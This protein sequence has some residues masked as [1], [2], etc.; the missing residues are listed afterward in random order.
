MRIAVIFTAHTLWRATLFPQRILLKIRADKQKKKKKKNKKSLLFP[1]FSFFSFSFSL[2][3]FC[4]SLVR[5]TAPVAPPPLGTPL[6]PCQFS[7]LLCWRFFSIFFFFL[8]MVIY[9]FFLSMVIFFFFFLSM[10]IFF[11]W[12]FFF[13]FFFIHGFFFFFLLVTRQGGGGQPA[14]LAPLVGTPLV[15][16][17]GSFKLINSC[18]RFYFVRDVIP[19]F[20]S[21]WL[22]I[23]CTIKLCIYPRGKQLSKDLDWDLRFL[24]GRYWTS[25]SCR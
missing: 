5:E 7:V 22:K 13:F 10:V 15:S 19:Q 1:P 14:P 11:P 9:I 25:S 18:W 4:L 3:F 17:K 12:W 24:L 2:F 16:F 23:S 21:R 6:P 20:R 8:S